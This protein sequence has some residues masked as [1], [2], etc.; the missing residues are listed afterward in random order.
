M[1]Y[2]VVGKLY[3]A[4]WVNFTLEILTEFCQFHPKLSQTRTKFEGKRRRGDGMRRET[5]LVF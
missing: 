3:F 1:T 5:Y 2:L 4:F